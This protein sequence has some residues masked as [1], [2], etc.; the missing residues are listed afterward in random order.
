MVKPISTMQLS[1]CA[2]AVCVCVCFPPPVPLWRRWWMWSW[3]WWT[4]CRSCL[5]HLTF[6]LRSA[7]PSQHH[8]RVRSPEPAAPEEDNKTNTHIVSSFKQT[9]WDGIHLV[10]H[11]TPHT[12]TSVSSDWAVP[13]QGTQPTAAASKRTAATQNGLYCTCECVAERVQGDSRWAKVQ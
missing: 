7:S 1:F 13:E 2:S 6:R 12:L 5:R 9:S 10:L 4:S 11:V 3:S 8:S